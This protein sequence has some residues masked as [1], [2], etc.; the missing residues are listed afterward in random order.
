MD[1]DTAIRRWA[2]DVGQQTSNC[3]GLSSLDIPLGRGGTTGG[4]TSVCERQVLGEQAG[5]GDDAR[6]R[7]REV[8]SLHSYLTINAHD[9]AS[10]GETKQSHDAQAAKY[11]RMM[12]T[13]AVLLTTHTQT[14]QLAKEVDCR[15]T[16]LTNSS[17]DWNASAALQITPDQHSQTCGNFTSCSFEVRKDSS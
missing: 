15:S 8:S 10:T 2:L 4:S 14:G 5:E 9:T 7:Q 16:T 6:R 3:G 1:R 12:E 11:T 17:M 13:L